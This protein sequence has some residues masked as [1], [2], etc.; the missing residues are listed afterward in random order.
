MGETGAAKKYYNGQAHCIYVASVDVGGMY[1]AFDFEKIAGHSSSEDQRSA[2][3]HKVCQSLADRKVNI[4]SDPENKPW[5]PKSPAECYIEHG[6]AKQSGHGVLLQVARSL[7]A[8]R[9]DG[10]KE[11]C[12]DDYCNKDFQFE[13]YGVDIC[14]SQLSNALRQ[15]CQGKGFGEDEPGDDTWNSFGGTYYVDCL[16]W[17]IVSAAPGRIPN[18]TFPLN[19]DSAEAAEVAFIF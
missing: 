7:S 12:T 8:C 15:E 2:P 17:T 11:G 4:T 1:D 13:S 19:I 3:A 9:G 16:S 10:T 5:G 6:A 14:V 18:E